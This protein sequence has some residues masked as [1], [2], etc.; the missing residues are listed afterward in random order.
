MPCY[1][2][3]VKIVN[4]FNNFLQKRL[5]KLFAEPSQER[6]QNKFAKL[7]RCVKSL[8]PPVE[9]LE[10]SWESVENKLGKSFSSDMPENRFLILY[11][12]YASM[13]ALLA[14][15]F[16]QKCSPTMQHR[17]ISIRILPNSVSTPY[18]FLKVFGFCINFS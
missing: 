16:F 3:I 11:V 6:I 15:K 9:N 10:I 14:R 2:I 7:R 1:S 13:L 8:S 5:Q 4:P 17:T 12:W 18:S